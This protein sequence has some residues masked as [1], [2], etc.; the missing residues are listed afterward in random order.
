[1]ERKGGEEEKKQEKRKK[2][3][4]LYGID[5]G[6]SCKSEMACTLGVA[7]IWRRAC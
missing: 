1:M 5:L 4:R 6:V 3:R 7:F 2:I